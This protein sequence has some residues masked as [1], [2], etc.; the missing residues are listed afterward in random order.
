MKSQFKYGAY[1]TATIAIF[2]TIML[3]G[4]LSVYLFGMHVPI[5][6]YLVVNCYFILVWF[7]MVAGELRTKVIS[8][9]IG[10]DHFIVRR[11]FGLGASHTYYFNDIEG[12][13]TA[14]L[15]AKGASYEFLYM[16]SGGKK[17]IKLSQFYH[18]NYADLKEHIAMLKIK[19]LGFEQFRYGREIKEIFV[20]L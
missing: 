9:E 18:K 17:I 20:K 5:A 11:Y 16:V 14:I 4:T 19:D 8:V 7:W 6:F 10:F 12:Y 15:P 3:I 2:F 1:I 13:E